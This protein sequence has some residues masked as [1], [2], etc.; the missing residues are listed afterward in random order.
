VT[1]CFFG[2]GAGARHDGWFGFDAA[3]LTMTAVHS[4]VPTGLI[5]GLD[6][7]I[8]EPT[9]P[10]RTSASPRKLVRAGFPTQ[11]SMA[12]ASIAVTSLPADVRRTTTLHVKKELIGRW[13]GVGVLP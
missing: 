11:P 7:A 8:R 6:A 1:N 13:L 5:F 9:R 10:S 3:V 2:N 4:V 12:S